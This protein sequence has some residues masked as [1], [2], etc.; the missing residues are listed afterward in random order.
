MIL[1]KVKGGSRRCCAVGGQQRRRSCCGL[2]RPTCLPSRRSGSVCCNYSVG[3]TNFF[4]ASWG[5]W[6]LKICLCKSWMSATSACMRH[7]EKL[8]PVAGWVVRCGG[9]S[10]RRL[11]FE[12]LST[13]VALVEGR[14]ASIIGVEGTHLMWCPSQQTGVNRASWSLTNV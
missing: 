8:T 7:T 2:R 10:V 3:I 1:H 11:L 6:S 14:R 9:G 13:S 12:S 4:L 5:S